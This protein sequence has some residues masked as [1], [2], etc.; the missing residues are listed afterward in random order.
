MRQQVLDEEIR[1]E[2]LTCAAC[3]RHPW[4][5]EVDPEKLDAIVRH[6]W[7][8]KYPQLRDRAPVVTTTVYGKQTNVLNK[9]G[10]G[11]CVFLDA[12]NLCLLH[13]ELGFDAKPQICKRF[14]YFSASMPDKDHVSANF[15][16]RGVQADQ[17]PDMFEAQ[18]RILA[19]VPP[20]RGPR[21]G[22]TEV[23][24]LVGHLIDCASAHALCDLWAAPFDPGTSANIW[25]RYALA[26]RYLVTAVRAVPMFRYPLSCRRRLRG[27]RRSSH[28]CSS[29]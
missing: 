17:G 24:L 23:A 3:C 26:M 11:A 19:Q 8:A 16:C 14:P 15:A 1:Y 5:V 10:Q 7:A 25:R 20:G 6:D 27:G 22:H 2:C 21:D 9:N 13:K 12:D 4:L 29:R 18:E 28:G